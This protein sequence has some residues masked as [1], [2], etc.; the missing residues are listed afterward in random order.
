MASRLHRT[1]HH[2]HHTFAE[3]KNA[4]VDTLSRI[5]T[6]DMPVV[7]TTEK[8]LREQETDEELKI[9]LQTPTNLR[10]RKPQL[11]D[12]N[13][14]IYCDVSEKDVRPYVPLSLRRAIFDQKSHQTKIRMA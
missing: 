8:L 14:T 13:R 6:I 12:T 9:L 11:D 10:L 3:K 2:S 7:I 1:I 4:A 5:Q